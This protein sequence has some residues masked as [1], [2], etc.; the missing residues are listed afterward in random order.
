MGGVGISTGG[1]GVGPIFISGPSMCFSPAGGGGFAV[2]VSGRDR[3]WGGGGGRGFEH[4]SS[5][6]VGVFGMLA[7]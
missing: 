3:C 1:R 7:S 2:H 6:G 5:F 4:I